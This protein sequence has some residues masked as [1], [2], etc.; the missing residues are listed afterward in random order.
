MMKE[1]VLSLLWRRVL[2]LNLLKG[3]A[4][5]MLRKLD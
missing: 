4:N 3:F 1:S 5:V 2:D